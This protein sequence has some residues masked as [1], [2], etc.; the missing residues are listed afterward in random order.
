MDLPTPPLLPLTKMMGAFI[1]FVSRPERG[2]VDVM[3]F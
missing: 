2:A 1:D 3:M